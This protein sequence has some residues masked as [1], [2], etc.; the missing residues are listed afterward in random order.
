MKN[1]K[2]C[3]LLLFLFI[4]ARLLAQNNDVS[5][6]VKEEA[7]QAASS[8]LNLIPVGEEKSYGFNS[9]ID[10]SKV[11]IEEPYQTYYVTNRNDKLGFVSG[12]EWR[13]PLSV[14][15]NYVALLTARINM[16]KVEIVDFGAAKLAQK[17]QELEILYS[18][19]TS[20]HILIRNIFLK[21]DYISVNFSLLGDTNKNTDFV[22]IN[23]DS[24]EPIY[25]L[26]E[27]RPI[28]TSITKFC[29]ETMTKI[30]DDSY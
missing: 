10:F 9:R 28:K 5:Q 11:K 1:K 12:N 7:S 21:Q 16:G 13:I 20:Q 8:F 30:N 19:K 18:S 17:I 14:D 3:Y 26:N 27:G 29:N 25:Q 15:G 24:S 23:I 6:L 22:D 2:T 4:S